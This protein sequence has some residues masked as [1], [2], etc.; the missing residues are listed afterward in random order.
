MQAKSPEP[1]SDS[2]RSRPASV[3]ERVAVSFAGVYRDDHRLQLALLAFM[4]LFYGSILGTSWRLSLG[5]PLNRTFNSMLG[6]L[7]RGQFDVDPQIVGAEGFLRNGHVYA[8]WGLWCALLR[9]PLWVFRCLDLDMTPWSCLTAVCLAG[10]AKVRAV[11]LVRRHGA[12]NP[13]AARVVGLMLI[14]IVLGGGETGYLNV[15][16]YQEVVFWAFAFAEVFV[17]LT[18]KGIVLGQF[19]SGTLCSMALVTGLSILTRVSSGIG[20][21]LAM[22]LL[23]VVLAVQDGKASGCSASWVRNAAPG[24]CLS[25]LS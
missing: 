25:S 21:L 9:L 8:Y 19:D 22:M 12:Q 23:L 11:L 17:Y 7:L 15:S 24:A 18:V 6:H 3:G 1:L 14:Y 5:I 10:M 16:L 4:V 20:L 2:R 13:I